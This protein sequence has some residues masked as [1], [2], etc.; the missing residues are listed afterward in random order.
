MW[1][2]SKTI[3][4]RLGRSSQALHALPEAADM[5]ATVVDV[6]E[7]G[8]EDDGPAGRRLGGAGLGLM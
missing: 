7:A 5:A 6:P 2:G 4:C 3:D 1:V 8:E